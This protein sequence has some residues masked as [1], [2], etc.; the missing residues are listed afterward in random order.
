MPGTGSAILKSTVGGVLILVATAAAG[1]RARDPIAAWQSSLTEHVMTVGHGDPS[2]LRD[3]VDRQ[4]KRGARPARISFGELSVR[5]P[6][7]APFRKSWDVQGVLV[8]R[9]RI[10]TAPWFFFVVGVM[11]AETRGN[12]SVKDLRLAAFTVDGEQIHWLVTDRDP[13]ATRRYSSFAQVPGDPYKVFPATT[14]VF[15][16]KISGR[17]VTVTERRTGTT[18]RLRMGDRIETPDRQ[19]TANVQDEAM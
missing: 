19:V 15:R 8:G 3:L 4:P 5:G 9:A 1:C 10:A 11:N 13:E 12:D 14:D 6:G 2:V 18:W 17:T 7:I 16:M